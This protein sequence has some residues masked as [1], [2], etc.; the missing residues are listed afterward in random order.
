MKYT[1]FQIGILIFTILYTL[2][3]TFIFLR[4]GN[5]EFLGYVVV[6]VFFI[7]LIWYLHI[8]FNFT[9][10]VLFGMSIWG[11]LHMA[12]GGIIINNAVLYA[13][14][15]LP[16]LKYDMFVHA[17]GFGMAT[18]LSYQILKNS[19]VKDVSRL[20]ISIFLV[21][22]GMGLGALNEIVE[23]VMTLLIANTGVGGY[24]NT[25]L[26]IIFNTIGSIIAAIY[27]DLKREKFK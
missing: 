21:F 26:D 20:K 11:L 3:F 7:L 2:I 12:G 4:R 18:I 10:G 15:L 27:V 19:F 22:I 13:Y 25:M 17:F 23:F 5:Y 6:L 14:W 1:K 24:E 16:F 8:L 9:T